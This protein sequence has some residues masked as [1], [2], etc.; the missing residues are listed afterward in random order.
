MKTLN[1][2]ECNVTYAEHQPEYI[3]LPTLCSKEGKV[4]SCWGLSF[5][6]RLKVLITGKIWLS[7]LTFNQRLQPLLMSVDKPSN[8][9]PGGTT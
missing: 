1:F 8:P 6:E 7:V 2:K 4:V 5:I 3:P 9:T